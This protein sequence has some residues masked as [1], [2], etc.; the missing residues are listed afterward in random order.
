MFDK[1]KY[2][3]EWHEDNP[4][5]RKEWYQ[6]NKEREN[7]RQREYYYSHL[8]ERREASRVSQLKR[9][10]KIKEYNKKYQRKYFLKRRYDITLEN[11]SQMV[12][13]QEGK[14]AICN[15]P[16]DSLCVDHNHL[17]GEVRGLLCS[18]C[19]QGIGLLDE[20]I[21]IFTKA[22]DYLKKSI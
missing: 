8:D 1:K 20:N 7:K 3:K 4:N 16:F 22:I 2:N 14:C 11:Y 5:Y 6:K 13:E 19:N 15:K 10:D 9:K 12:E 18:K 17:T 21:E